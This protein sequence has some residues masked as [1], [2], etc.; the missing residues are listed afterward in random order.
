[1]NGM[2]RELEGRETQLGERYPEINLLFMNLCGVPRGELQKNFQA[3]YP[4]KAA[5]AGP[6]VVR[7]R[8]TEGR[9]AQIGELRHVD[10]FFSS[11]SGDL[12]GGDRERC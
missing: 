1:M 6:A 5:W 7:A 2:M 8:C 3:A 12:W 4:Q 11:R 10:R 9:G